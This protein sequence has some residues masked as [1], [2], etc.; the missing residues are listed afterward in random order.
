VVEDFVKRALFL[1]TVSEHAHQRSHFCNRLALECFLWGLGVLTLE[2]VDF[3]YSQQFANELT[4]FANLHK[5][6][7]SEEDYA[8]QKKIMTRYS[9]TAEFFANKFKD[10]DFSVYVSA[11]DA[12]RTRL[13]ALRQPE[14][15]T[16]RI[17]ELAELRLN[18]P[19]PTRLMIDEIIDLMRRGRFLVRPSYQR[20]E[21]INPTKMSAIIESVLLGITLPSLFIFKKLDGTSEVIDGQQRILTLIGYLQEE[22]TDQNGARARSKNHGFK[23]KKLRVLKEL[24]GLGFGDL[25]EDQQERIFEFPL[26]IVEIKQ[27]QN[28]NF[29]P[30][31]LFIRLNDKPYPIREHS[32]EMWNSWADVD[33]I[34]AVKTLLRANRGWFYLKLLGRPMDRDRMEN[35]ELL[36]TLAFL[37]Y[38]QELE[39]DRKYLDVYQ[40]TE[41]VNLRLSNK[42]YIS[43]ILQEAL[44]VDQKK[45]QVMSAV[46]GVERF[47]KNVKT[48]LIDRDCR[49]EELS[50]YLRTELDEVFRS[51]KRIRAFKRTKQDFYALWQLLGP[52]Q[53]VMVRS[54]RSEIK[55]AV[56][57]V[58]RF[59]KNIPEHMHMDNRG[60]REYGAL[61]ESFHERFAVSTRATKLS[62]HEVAELLK[63]QG[64]RCGIS[65]APIFLGDDM[66]V[67]HIKPLAV[68]GEDTKEN[69]QLAHKEE[70]RKKGYH[71]E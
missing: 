36:M 31:D 5:D 7:Y 12:A 21:V 9:A 68:G 43:T 28:P 40:K 22:Y 8:F 26:Q 48:V 49:S 3:E 33:V 1:C 71:E 17:S 65:G 27:E 64:N 59:M 18:K 42:S 53:P 34:E 58:F 15:A 6:S 10:V 13:K 37:S 16:T 39:S 4:M 52:L 54:N 32:F 56:V 38:M 25:E 60:L 2:G 41:R 67:D 23:L 29:N 30:V 70:N 11:D 14:D 57:A 35:E 66:E 44:S 63:R 62:D 47:V 51:G 69:L 45:V 46:K 55:Q 20:K 61:V 50:A 24:E 19:E